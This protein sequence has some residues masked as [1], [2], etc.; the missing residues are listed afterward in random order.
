MIPFEMVV[1]DVFTNSSAK[2]PV[3]HWDDLP[4]LQPGTNMER[5]RA[6]VR[7]FLSAH[8][9]HITIHK[10]RAISLTLVRT[11]PR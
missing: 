11:R 10:V 3:G 6:K 2:I 8:E 1:G 5:F 7:Q 9:N 4:H